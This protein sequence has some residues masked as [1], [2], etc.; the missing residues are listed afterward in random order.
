[1]NRISKR[2]LIGICFLLIGI[3]F[4]P[5]EINSQIEFSGHEIQS[6]YNTPNDVLE[7]LESS[8]FDC[9]SNKTSYPWYSSLQPFRYFM[10]QHIHDGK[11]ELN[12]SEFENYSQR[13]K[14]NKLSS[15]IS[16]INDDKMP[17]SSYL[18]LHKNAKLSESEKLLITNWVED[19]K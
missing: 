16:Q 5:A 18:L 15:I 2:I 6:I 19:I 7:Q 17:P 9:H 14:R 8:C 12:F 1:M 4:I 11:K 13:R 10:D 3:Q